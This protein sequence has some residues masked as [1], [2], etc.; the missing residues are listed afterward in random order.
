[1]QPGDPDPT[2]VMPFEFMRPV[3]PNP[4]RSALPGNVRELDGTPTVGQVEL[5]KQKE[6][7]GSKAKAKRQQAKDPKK[8]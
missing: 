5:V 6:E 8:G 1:L 7:K 4:E 2:P 3:A